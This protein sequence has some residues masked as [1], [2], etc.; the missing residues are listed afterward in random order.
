[1]VQYILAHSTKKKILL[2]PTHCGDGAFMSVF[3]PNFSSDWAFY[4]Q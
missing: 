4:L 3:A 2:T 1:M